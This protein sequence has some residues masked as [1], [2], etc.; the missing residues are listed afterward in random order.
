MSLRFL[1][2]EGNVRE[3]REG[4]RAGQGVT[5][6]EGYGNVLVGIAGGGMYDILH[7]T[8][9]DAALPAG[10]TFADYDA[11]VITGSALHL[12]QRQPEALRQ[13][14]V[15]KAIYRAGIPF[16]GSCWG[17]QVAAVAAGG[18]VQ[19]NPR[20]REMGFARRIMRTPAGKLHPLLAGRPDVYDAP[21][22]HLDE[23]A[24][25]PPDST[26]LASNAMSNVQAAEFR[27]EG[28]TFWGVQYHPEYTLADLAFLIDRRMGTLIEEGFFADEA[29][30]QRHVETLRQLA[31]TVVPRD[32]CWQLGLDDEVVDPHRRMTELRNFIDARVRPYASRRAAA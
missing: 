3:T 9:A 17:I 8:D 12:W 16:F 21:C 26:I 4:Y 27:S 7:A 15:A 32:L 1:I 19:R 22:S 13:V 14:E 28:G 18:D 25:P 24:V 29:A 2:I 11:A 20:G 10:M 6:A 23:V 5:P 30:K 31:E